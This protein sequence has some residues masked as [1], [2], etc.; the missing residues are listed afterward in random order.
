MVVWYIMVEDIVS[1]RAVK[2]TDIP[3]DIDEKITELIKDMEGN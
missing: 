1:G 3:K 2:L